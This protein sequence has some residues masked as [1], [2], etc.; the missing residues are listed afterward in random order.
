MPIRML[1]R[2]VMMAWQPWRLRHII[3]TKR[4]SS[5]SGRPG[6]RND[7]PACSELAWHRRHPQRR[8]RV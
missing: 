3:A 8:R 1:L 7:L 4:S 5:C 2:E 6:L